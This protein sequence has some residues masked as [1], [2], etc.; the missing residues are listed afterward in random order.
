MSGCKVTSSGR[1][2][3]T[4]ALNLALTVRDLIAEN[5]TTVPTIST[6]KT[7]ETM[8]LMVNWLLSIRIR[9]PVITGF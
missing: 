3:V 7:I 8:G 1:Y 9:F 5:P 2:W 4:L 6:P